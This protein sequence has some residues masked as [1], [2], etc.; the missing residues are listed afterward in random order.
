MTRSNMVRKKTISDIVS[1]CIELTIREVDCVLIIKFD[2][3]CIV[4]DS[5]L[6]VALL[7]F[8]VAQILFE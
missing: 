8:I 2:G 3:S 6:I 5:L 7:E 1:N 4:T